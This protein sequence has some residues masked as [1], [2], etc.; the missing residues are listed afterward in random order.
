MF[1]SVNEGLME[2]EEPIN[3]RLSEP[4]E[5]AE[6]AVSPWVAIGS[7]TPWFAVWLAGS[8][9]TLAAS[10]RAIRRFTKVLELAKHA[11]P[12]I[13][14]QVEEAAALIGLSRA[15]ETFL[16]DWDRPPMVWAMGC[17]PSLMIPNALWS[18]LD[19]LQR[20]TLLVHELAH[21]KRGDHVVRWLELAVS[22]L[23]WW[24]P[25]VWWTRQALREAEEDCCDAWVIWA[26]PKSAR[27]YADTLVETVD[28]L[29]ESRTQAPLLASGFGHVRH[30]KRRLRMIMQG[31][32]TRRLRLREVFAVLAMGAAFLPLNPSWAEPQDPPKE[33]KP[34]AAAAKVEVTEDRKEENGTL[35]ITRTVTTTSDDDGDGDQD[36]QVTVDAPPV[37]PA[38]AAVPPGS[39]GPPPPPA[40]PIP[41]TPAGERFFRAEV[42]SQSGGSGGALSVAPQII[43]GDAEIAATIRRLEN[44]VK[45]LTNN[46]VEKNKDRQERRIQALKQAIETLQGTLKEPLGETK[47]ERKARILIQRRNGSSSP[48]SA[49]KDSGSDGDMI[50]ERVEPVVVAREIRVR[51]NGEIVTENLR[52]V[53]EGGRAVENVKDEIRFI[54]EKIE[55]HRRLAKVDSDPTI[56]DLELKLNELKAELDAKTGRKVELKF[57]GPAFVDKQ[58]ERLS[59][60]E[61]TLEK[62]LSELQSLKKE[63]SR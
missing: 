62:V 63:K 60:L 46:P 42:R 1:T 59:A 29:S 50:V 55:E 17:R 49:S 44:Q 39:P 19:A 11:S 33:D 31:N 25:A 56:R 13:Q 23:F 22:V 14:D 27:R 9:V 35:T 43:S 48:R 52:G 45:L 4:M 61:K 32:T 58:E 26:L 16:M 18:R 28:F 36:V 41:P 47:P 10:V 3:I 21:L 37:P 34:V 30:L 6:A 8:L 51:P 7:S 53:V 20:E 40:A 57:G 5:V 2:I 15:P 24:L 12:A 38:P 54:R